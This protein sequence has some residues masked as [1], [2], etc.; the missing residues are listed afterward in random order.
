MYSDWKLYSCKAKL[1][2]YSLELVFLLLRSHSSGLWSDLT[3]NFDRCKYGFKHFKA[4]NKPIEEL[5]PS[6]VSCIFVHAYSADGI[7]KQQGAPNLQTPCITLSLFRNHWLL[8]CTQRIGVICL[9]LPQLDNCTMLP[10][11][12]EIILQILE[13]NESIISFTFF[14]H[15]FC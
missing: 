7:Y 2:L 15:E 10:S 6:P 11:T 13:S 4:Y 5:D 8:Q 14:F 12:C 3:T 1:H 9:E